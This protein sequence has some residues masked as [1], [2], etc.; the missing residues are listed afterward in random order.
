MIVTRWQAQ[1]IPTKEQII[2]IFRN[3][4][5]SPEEEI[6]YVDKPVTD[7]KHPF[8]EVRMIVSGEMIMNIS[9]NKILLRPGDKIL[10]PSNTNH[11]KE[12]RGPEPCV[13]IYAKKVFQS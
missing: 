9:G 6:F 5:L 12:V 2:N 7:H 11:A 3:E 1:I 13:S 4:D 10:V 8:D